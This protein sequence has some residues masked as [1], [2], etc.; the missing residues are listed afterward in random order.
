[1]EQVTETT[2]DANDKPTV[3]R[4]T[5]NKAESEKVSDWIKQIQKFTNGYLSVSRS[6]IVNFLIREHKSQLTAKEMNQIKVNHYDP[7]KHL[8][9]ISQELRVALTSEDKDRVTLLQNELKGIELNSSACIKPFSAQST[10]TSGFNE[11]TKTIQFKSKRKRKKID[12]DS[13]DA[14]SVADLQESVPEA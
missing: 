10:Q 4:A 14:L 7:L 6:E 2:S 3:E 12:R 8:A 1:M 11:E 9:W 13:A 5:L